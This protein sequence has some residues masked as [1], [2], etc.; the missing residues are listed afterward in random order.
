MEFRLMELK[1]IHLEGLLEKRF[2]VGRNS[3]EAKCEFCRKNICGKIRISKN[4]KAWELMVDSGQF[5]H[6][7]GNPQNNTLSNIWLLCDV[8]HKRLHDWGVIQ[9]WLEKINKTPEDLPD[10]TS[11]AVWRKM[12][13]KK[14]ILTNYA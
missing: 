9:R 8:C 11:L 3:F 7:D 12:E 1:R 5:H 6:K 10:C 14:R 4:N 2:Q 13:Y